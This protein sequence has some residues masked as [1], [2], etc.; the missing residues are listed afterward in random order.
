VRSDFIV[1]RM[2]EERIVTKVFKNTQKGQKSVG[3]R[4]KRWLDDS[5]NDLK[6]MDVNRLEKKK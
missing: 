2:P 5:E 4:R 6:K 3:M 1:E